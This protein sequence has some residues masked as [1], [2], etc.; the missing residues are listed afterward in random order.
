MIGLANYIVLDAAVLETDLLIAETLNSNN[1][2]LYD[3]NSLN[4][5]R[6]VAPYLFTYK[7][8]QEFSTWLIAKWAT[9]GVGISLYSWATFDQVYEHLKSHLYVKT[10][11]NEDLYFRFYDPRCL[12][13]FLRSCNQ[14]Q[15]IEFFGP[16]KFFYL[17]DQDA[18][19]ALKLWHENGILKEERIQIDYASLIKNY[20]DANE[21][22]NEFDITEDS[23]SVAD[24]E[25]FD[26]NEDEAENSIVPEDAEEKIQ[27]QEERVPAIENKTDVNES[28]NTE[29][30]SAINNPPQA[31]GNTKQSASFNLFDDEDEHDIQITNS[32]TAPSTKASEV[33]SVNTSEK[34]TTNNTMQPAL[35]TQNNNTPPVQ[36]KPEAPPHK[37]AEE[38]GWSLFDE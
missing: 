29:N 17:E 30:L 27:P 21:D 18:N 10:E 28:T 19:F 32:N 5:F 9:K 20:A 25:F 13:I 16:I 6:F 4:Y 8:N 12:R 11:Q 14:L 26:N 15:I 31:Q 33:P 24:N 34:Q 1:R 36:N 23:I 22:A 3:E 7:L 37:P 35:P 2:C 38:D